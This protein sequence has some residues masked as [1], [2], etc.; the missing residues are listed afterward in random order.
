MNALL[1]GKQ[2]TLAARRKRLRNL[3]GYLEKE[4]TPE[5]VL[6]PYAERVKD[7]KQH[8][9][10]KSVIFQSVIV[11]SIQVLQRALFHERQV[12]TAA[13]SLGQR[14]K[15]QQMTAAIEQTVDALQ[16]ALTPQGKQMLDLAP[17]QQ[18]EKNDEM[19]WWFVLS[20]A[21][22][23]LEDGIDWI[24]SVVSS[25]PR[26][27]AARLLSSVIVRLLYRHHQELQ[28]EAEHWLVNVK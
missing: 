26:G 7:L 3:P 9:Q 18:D 8:E 13:I 22:Q 15:L 28:D 23:A 1:T 14:D 4:E 12:A 27:G 6:I 11:A 21:M 25:Q 20:D 19:N 16:D 24:K 5:G 2:R 10:A 17:E